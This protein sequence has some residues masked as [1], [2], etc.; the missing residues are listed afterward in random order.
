MDNLSDIYMHCN[1]IEALA[2][3]MKQKITS[4][5]VSTEE[6][7]QFLKDVQKI[8]TIMIDKLEYIIKTNF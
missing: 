5:P 2:D 3:A 1:K 4:G 6:F 8:D 7:V